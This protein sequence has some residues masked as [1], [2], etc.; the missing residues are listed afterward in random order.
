MRFG[1]ALPHYD[2]SVPG[3][4]RASFQEVARWAARAEEL[5]FDS[6]WISD[7]FF[8]TLSRYGGSDAPQGSLE[9]MT[10]LAGLAA[11][12][13]RVRIGTL[14]ACAQ[15]RHPAVL[16]KM[17]STI[18]LLSGGRL[19][20]GIGAGWFD[21]ELE[22]FGYPAS[23]RIHRFGLLEEQ[24][25]ILRR[26]FSNGPS[27]YDGRDT[28]LRDAVMRPRAHQRPGPPVWLGSKGGP[29]TLS[30][31]ARL[32]DGWNSVWRWD[33]AEY[34]GRVAAA[35]RA[36]ADAGRDPSSARMS[37]GLYTIVGEDEPDWRARFEHLAALQ[38]G[39]EA[40]TPES[41]ARTT[42]GGAPDRALERVGELAALG[43]EEIIVTIG[44]LPFAMPDAGMLDVL[45][46][47]VVAEG[48]AL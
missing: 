12:T 26:L 14:V 47:R 44:H 7:H 28:T 16:A 3:R 40:E 21:R 41:F 9:P 11:R 5:G 32:A 20:L 10:A 45:A 23:A 48:R 43:V 6:V 22:A 8:L 30:M 15:F 33:P 31:A 19:D 2:F 37:L 25:E 27:S 18:D 36:W 42:L 39:L 35:R 4:A 13:S 17:A 1:L 38:P 24:L 34:A 46:H 29:R